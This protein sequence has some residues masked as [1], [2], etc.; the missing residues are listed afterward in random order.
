VSDAPPTR[1]RSRNRR[2]GEV[3]GITALLLVLVRGDVSAGSTSFRDARPI[4]TNQQ[5]VTVTLC[6]GQYDVALA[7]GSHRQFSERNLAFKVETGE[8]GPP[9]LSPVLVLSRRVP[10]RAFVVFP[11]LE[12]LRAIVKSG[13]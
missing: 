11:S 12:A 2:L 8:F 10:D 13:C 5:V 6:H 3:A 1:A 4:P 7:D 9:P